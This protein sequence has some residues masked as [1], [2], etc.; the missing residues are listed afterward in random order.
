VQLHSLLRM[1]WNSYCVSSNIPNHSIYQLINYYLHL[2]S[3]PVD[4]VLHIS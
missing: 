2:E 4:F 1:F 3:P